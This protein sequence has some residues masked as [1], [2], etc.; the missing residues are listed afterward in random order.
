MKRVFFRCTHN[1]ARSQMAEGLLRQLGHGQFAAFS[2]GTQATQVRPEAIAVMEELG[3]AISKQAE[4]LLAL[5]EWIKEY[6]V[7]Q[8][9]TLG[10]QRV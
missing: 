3:I 8:G 4:L 1:A 2:A 10:D 9:R 6:V 5:Q 7:A